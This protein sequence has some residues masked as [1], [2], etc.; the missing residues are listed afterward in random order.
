MYRMWE[1]GKEEKQRK[2]GMDSYSEKKQ[3]SIES[4]YFSYESKQETTQRAV[5]ILET[6]QLM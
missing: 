4:H 2:G 5:N 6:G 1:K 3:S